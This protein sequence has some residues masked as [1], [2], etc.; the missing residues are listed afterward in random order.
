MAHGAWEEQKPKGERC[1]MCHMLWFI[2]GLRG[3][4]E[5]RRVTYCAS[6]ASVGAL[7][8][9]CPGELAVCSHGWAGPGSLQE[10]AHAGLGL[11]HF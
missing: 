5:G 4:V 3:D 9:G 6:W 8:L 11:I 2:G 1:A 10:L 7:G